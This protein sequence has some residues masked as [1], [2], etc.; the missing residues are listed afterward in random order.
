M[1]DY[2]SIIVK[3]YVL[4]LSGREIAKQ[5]GASKSGVLISDQLRSLG[6]F[7]FSIAL[8]M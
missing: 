5:I 4:N 7:L 2:K 6:L 3:R 8:P 1:L